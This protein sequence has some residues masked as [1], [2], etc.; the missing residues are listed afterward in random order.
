M[1]NKRKRR[2]LGD[3]GTYDA[4]IYNGGV[5]PSVA[6]YPNYGSIATSDS[7]GNYSVRPATRDEWLRRQGIG[8]EKASSSDVRPHTFDELDYINTQP[9][10]EIPQAVPNTVVPNYMYN[11]FSTPIDFRTRINRRTRRT[12]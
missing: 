8:I 9:L 11:L 3:L 12:K 4:N 1:A 7:R 5:L 10:I 2:Y 6:I